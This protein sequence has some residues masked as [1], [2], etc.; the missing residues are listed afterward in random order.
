MRIGLIAAAVIGLLASEAG[1]QPGK[2]AAQA[3]FAEG[4]Q[5]YAAGEYLP[6]ASKFEA[7]YAADPDPV[8]LFNVAQA[9]RLGRQCPKAVSYYKRF[10]AA[11]PNPPNLTKVNQYLEQ[12]QA[13]ANAMAPVEPVTTTTPPP[14][15]LVTA[16]LVTEQPASDDP[17]RSRRWVG[18]GAMVLG[19]AALGFGAFYTTE[20][21]R[22]TGERQEARTKCLSNPC[23]PGYGDAI[24]AE[25]ERAERRAQISYA[26]SG[27]AVIGGVVLYVLG[28]S[29]ERSTVAVIP[30]ADG[31][32]AVGA[33][34]F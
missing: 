22:L 19:G 10:L 2:V 21:S 28:R 14:E 27:A 20:A 31:A 4:Q 13:C 29:S 1:A 17:G 15:P 12:S 34:R 9:Y 30:T 18:I 26:V 25:G 32:V 6:A 3:A 23:A 33:F 24:D 8:Y 16:P 5:R 7:A 11:V